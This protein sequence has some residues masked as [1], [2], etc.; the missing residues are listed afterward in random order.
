MKKKALIAI[1]IGGLSACA[2]ASIVTLSMS[3]TGSGSL[4]GVG[5]TDKTFTWDISYD[6]E[7]INSNWGSAQP[8]FTNLFSSVISLQD[9]TDPINITQDHGVWVYNTTAL[10]FAPIN[11][12]GNSAAGNILTVSDTSMPGWDGT[13]DYSQAGGIDAA[14]NQ[15]YNITTDQG[16]LELSSGTLDSV[17]AAIPEPATIGLIGLFGGGILAIRRLFLI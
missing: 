16:T 10:R 7:S 6:S 2:Q 8:I 11:M 4:D 9:E 14:F 15:F 1:I 12:S 5:F 17:N 3:G 13:S